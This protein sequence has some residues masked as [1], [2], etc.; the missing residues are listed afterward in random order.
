MPVA[1]FSHFEDPAATNLN[2]VQ[3]TLIEAETAVKRGEFD[4]EYRDQQSNDHFSGPLSYDGYPAADRAPFPISEPHSLVGFGFSNEIFVEPHIP[5]PMM[6][7]DQQAPQ[8]AESFGCYVNTSEEQL[9]IVEANVPTFPSQLLVGHG[10]QDA[11][12]RPLQL[13]GVEGE[14][15]SSFPLPASTIESRFK[16]PPPP[17]D[18]AARRRKPTPAALGTSALRDK[19]S[20]GPKTS[21]NAEAVKRL[22]GSPSGTMRRVSSASG[23][24]V[25]AGRVQK[26]SQMQL[27]SPLKRNFSAGTPM[28]QSPHIKMPTRNRSWLSNPH[29][30]PTPRSPR[31]MLLTQGLVLSEEP[32][33]QDEISQREGHTPPDQNTPSSSSQS[34]SDG[35]YMYDRTVPGCFPPHGLMA[36]MVSPPETPG[37][38]N[39]VLHWVGYDVPDDALLTPGFSSTFTDGMM[40]MPRPHYVSSMPASQPPTPAFG[41]FNGFPFAHNSPVFEMVPSFD[42]GASEYC[43][44][45][46]GLPYPMIASTKAPAEQPREKIY[47][48]SNATQKDFESS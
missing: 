28:E 23:L 40:Q 41:H 11:T 33:Q 24:N 46:S 31:D 18:I 39:S 25:L 26:S 29:G 32:L 5:Q 15:G 6:L 17:A 19:T 43:F 10:E 14:S 22:H 30:P 2:S 12:P 48:F 34:E 3:Q 4:D 36:N 13:Q 7:Q 47:T 44:P 9:P 38:P 16:S 37:N 45:E 42:P 1:S 27:R 21:N 8:V 35:G 20:T